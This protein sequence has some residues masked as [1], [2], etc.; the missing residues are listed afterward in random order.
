MFI[1]MP[2]T[3]YYIVYIQSNGLA[4]IWIWIAA[5]VYLVFYMV[6]CLAKLTYTWLADRNS[7]YPFDEVEMKRFNV[8]N[9]L[10]RI[11]VKQ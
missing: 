3:V 11:T 1:H 9:R 10:K 7:P 6:I 4:N 5:I 2:V 8:T